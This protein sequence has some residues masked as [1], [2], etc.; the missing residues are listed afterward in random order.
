MAAL[1]VVMMVASMGKQMVVSLDAQLV[2]NSAVLLAVT[3]VVR[4]AL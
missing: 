3:K 1:S 4:M 2:E